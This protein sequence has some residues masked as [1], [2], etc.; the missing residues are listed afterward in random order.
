MGVVARLLDGGT[1][2]WL[3]LGIETNFTVGPG[4]YPNGVGTLFYGNW[5]FGIGA[6]FAF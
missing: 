1:Q 5:D 3:G 4:F 6:R 2:Q